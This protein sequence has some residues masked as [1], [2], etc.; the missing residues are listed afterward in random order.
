LEKSE[1]AEGSMSLT[2]CS[3]G[4]VDTDDSIEKRQ[5]NEGVFYISC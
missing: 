5:S 1:K 2:A 4:G 3:F